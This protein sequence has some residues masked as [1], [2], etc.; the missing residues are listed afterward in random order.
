MA[1]EAHLPLYDAPT[2][3]SP[4]HSHSHYP[5]SFFSFLFRIFICFPQGPA[6]AICIHTENQDQASFRP[7]APWALFHFLHGMHLTL[8]F[9]ICLFVYMF[10]FSLLF[11]VPG[12]RVVWFQPRLSKRKKKKRCMCAQGRLAPGSQ[13]S[14]G[15]VRWPAG[16]R[17]DCSGSL[18]WGSS[19]T[20]AEAR[21]GSKRPTEAEELRVHLSLL[22]AALIRGQGSHLF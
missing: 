13:T 11:G 16:S 20:W 19:S 22:F 9:L 17:T 2:L 18:P 14:L 5:V 8:N 21:L 10:I 4:S 7:S 3:P 12:D 6:F 15:A 1:L